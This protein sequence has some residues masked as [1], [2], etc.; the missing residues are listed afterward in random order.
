MANNKRPTDG[1]DNQLP[2]PDVEWVTSGTRPGAFTAAGVKGILVNPLYA[3]A[4]P[5]PRIVSDAEWVGACTKLLQE[6]S[7]EQFLV[8]LLF[9]LRQSLEN[10]YGEDRQSL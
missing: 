6:E 3:G 10:L 9:V 5:F 4:G 8:N 1:E 7:A 2:R